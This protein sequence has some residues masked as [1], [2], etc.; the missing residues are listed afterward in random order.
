MKKMKEK[1]SMT[2]KKNVSAK[3]AKEE[4]IN[5]RCTAQQKRLL[6]NIASREGLGVST[7]LLHVGLRVAQDRSGGGGP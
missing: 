5:V 3:E 2:D 4:A 7:W 6:E 1:R